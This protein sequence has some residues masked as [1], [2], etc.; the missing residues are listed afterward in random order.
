MYLLQEAN[1]E[2]Y[3]FCDQDDIWLPD[4]IEKTYNRMKILEKSY[5]GIP[6]VVHTDLNVVDSNLNMISD[7]FWRQSKIKPNILRSPNYIGVCNCATG[8]TM[9][10]N[11]KAKEISLPMP[12]VADMHD[13]WVTLKTSMEGK[14]DYVDE[15]LILYRQHGNNVVGARKVNIKYF[16]KKIE[17]LKITIG[18]QLQQYRFLKAANYGSIFKFYFYKILYLIRRNL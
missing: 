8:C 1:S 9:M 11:Q 5:P 7:S 6:L 14:V 4:K 2:Y 10:F 16:I 17:H 13:W 18:G 15:A 3:M 12:D